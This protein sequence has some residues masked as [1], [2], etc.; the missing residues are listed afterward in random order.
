VL[1]GR[2]DPFSESVEYGRDETKQDCLAPFAYTVPVDFVIEQVERE[3]LLHWKKRRDSL[4]LIRLKAEAIL[5]A[6]GGVDLDLIAEMVGRT[7]KT[8]Q[9]WLSQWRASR[10]ESVVTGH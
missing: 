1:N 8:V 6:F 5:Y 4:I 10:L 3:V 9:G 2:D 7:R